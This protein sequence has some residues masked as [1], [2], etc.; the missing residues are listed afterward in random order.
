MVKRFVPFGLL[1][2]ILLQPAGH[3]I[4]F[5][6]LRY[7]VRREVAQRIFTG[8]DSSALAVVPIPVELEK[9]RGNR[10]HWVEEGEFRLDGRMYDVVCF[11]RRG[12]TTWYFC[13]EDEKETRL[14]TL[15]EADIRREMRGGEGRLQRIASL[16]RLCTSLFLPS[17]QFLQA[18]LPPG[19]LATAEQ[20]F[21]RS[22]HRPKPPSPPPKILRNTVESG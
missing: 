10:F 14:L 8:L 16:L 18:I 12:D 2:L 20:S 9:G 19:S 4:L 3:F 21:S 13:I 6:C 22:R 17:P 7:Q 15:L 5:E 11:E 1:A